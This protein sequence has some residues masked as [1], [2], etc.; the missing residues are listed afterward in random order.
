MANKK[1]FAN[2][3]NKTVATVPAMALNQAGGVA[4]KLS[5]KEALAQFAVTGCFGGTFY[6][7]DDS[8][9]ENAKK[10]VP[11]V[12][13]EFLAKLCL[14]SRESGF[15]KDAPAFLLAVL[16]VR[17]PELFKKVF[18]RVVD[19][20]K[21]LRNF[22]QIVRSGVTGRKS[23]GSMPKRLIAEWINSRTNE[24]LFN[25]AV[26]NDP[27]LKDVICM[28][29]PRPV[30][31]ER[32]AL[33]AYICENE[34]RMGELTEELP[35]VIKDFEAFKKAKAEERVVPSNVS[36]QRL[37]SLNLTTNDWKQIARGMSYNQLRMNLN[38]L[39]R[40]DVFVNGNTVDH[41]MVKYVVDRLSDEKAVA[42]VKVFPYELFAAYMNLD[43]K[44]PN[45]IRV[46]LEIAVQHSIKKLSKIEVDGILVAVDSSRSMQSPATGNRTVASKMSCNH[47]ASLMA[48]CLLAANPL[49]TKIVR[50]DTAVEEMNLSPANTVMQNASVLN[51]S[52]G[53]TNCSLPLAL[54]NKQGKKANLVVYLSD[55]ESWM[56][57]GGY[58]NSTGMKAEWEVFKKNNPQAKL[59]C[60]DITPNATTQAA[61]NKDVLNVGGFS[62]AVWTVIH[63]FL[64]GQGNFV[65]E[66][67]K[68]QI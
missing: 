9:L 67:E 30:N 53:G 15:M 47:V 24:Q 56:D 52:G 25:D 50:F 46:A 66:I 51:R 29:H 16:L 17:S 38:T 43:E 7:S 20:A 31:K 58:Y 68:I 3:T 62:S 60:I 8:Q 37:T 14:Y 26:G 34:K 5:D 27:S 48:S 33:Y 36:F 64:T 65:E 41:E 19:N 12:E 45:D 4:Y 61:T 1:L 44:V 54:W 57:R 42:K 22:V 49:T 2:K 21:M 28:S 23:L 63:S 59:V 13:P 32:E 39:A 6:A 35:K 40:H 18:P 11:L 55:N 10:L